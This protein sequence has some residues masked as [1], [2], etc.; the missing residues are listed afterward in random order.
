MLVPAGRRRE[1]AVGVLSDGGFERGH[2]GGVGEV[3]GPEQTAL[4]AGAL[5]RDGGLER[6]PREERVVEVERLALR[7]ALEP[8]LL[9]RLRRAPQRDRDVFGICSVRVSGSVGHERFAPLRLRWRSGLAIQ[10]VGCWDALEVARV[11]EEVGREVFAGQ[12]VGHE[13]LDH[14]R[15]CARDCEDAMDTL[16]RRLLILAP[17]VRFD[18]HALFQ[19]ML[20]LEVQ[21]CA[22]VGSV[23]RQQSVHRRDDTPHRLLGHKRFEDVDVR[24]DALLAQQPKHRL[25][26]LSPSHHVPH[27]P[28]LLLP[29]LSPVHSNQL[30]P[31]QDQ[32]GPR[33][34]SL[35]R[36]AFDRER[37]AL[38]DLQPEPAR[39]PWS[40][41]RQPRPRK[42]DR[43][44]FEADRRPDFGLGLGRR[45]FGL[46]VGRRPSLSL[47]CSPP[48]EELTPPP[49]LDPTDGGSFGDLAEHAEVLELVQRAPHLGLQDGCERHELDRAQEL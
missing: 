41:A 4:V 48:V 2:G 30:V 21:L 10:D 32:P 13:R 47:G 28:D 20:R 11:H 17:E 40:R 23:V 3:E 26:A 9:H 12:V 38:P 42:L 1:R 24:L 14:E 34:C 35:R 31:G 16:Q 29:Q 49:A 19:P 33:G 15:V 22:V 5:A 25:A 8:E 36:H 7:R 39:R 18:V 43:D 46:G 37:K 6:V 44:L 45:R 27:R